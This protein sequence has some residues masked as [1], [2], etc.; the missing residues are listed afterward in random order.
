M[1]I[2]LALFNL[3]DAIFTYLGVTHGVIRE[4][5]PLMNMLITS[6]PLF[7]LAT[8]VFLSFCLLVIGH[9]SRSLQQQRFYRVTLSSVTVLYGGV[10]LLHLY[11]IYPLL[12]S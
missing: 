10:F 1:Y 3:A 2:L 12:L 11:W 6:E 7:F 9:M 5:N 4:A 8:K